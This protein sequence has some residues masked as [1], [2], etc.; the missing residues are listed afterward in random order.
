R[1]SLTVGGSA[2]TLLSQTY[3][4]SSCATGNTV[5]RFSFTGFD[6]APVSVDQGTAIQLDL[7]VVRVERAP[8]DASLAAVFNADR[9]CGFTDW[10]MNQFKDV[11]GLICGNLPVARAGSKRYDLYRVDIPTLTLQLGAMDTVNDGTDVTKRPGRLDTARLFRHP[12]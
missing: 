4:G 6:G 1:D 12:F 7:T 10:T 8:L 3:T 11:T 2:F 5:S 9:Y